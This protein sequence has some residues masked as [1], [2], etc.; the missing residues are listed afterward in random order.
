MKHSWLLMHQFGLCC[1]YLCAGICKKRIGGR[2]GGS[3][4]MKGGCTWAQLLASSRSSVCRCPCKRP[5]KSP[6]T[7]PCLGPTAGSAELQQLRLEV[8]SLLRVVC[9]WR[10]LAHRSDLPTPHQTFAVVLSAKP[11]RLWTQ[12]R[13]FFLGM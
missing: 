12:V 3:V 7:R 4:A 9:Q 6:R 5:S 10:T 2:I 11:Q 8:E 1:L 13:C